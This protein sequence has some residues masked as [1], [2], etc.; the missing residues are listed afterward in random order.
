MTIANR[1]AKAVAVAKQGR[2]AE[3][4]SAAVED[5]TEALAARLLEVGS[6]CRF[7]ANHVMIEIGL[8]GSGLFLIREG[9][10]RVEAPERTVEMRAGE[11]VGDWALNRPDGLRTARVIC[12]T[13]V[14]AVAVDRPA[15]DAAVD[16]VAAAALAALPIASDNAPPRATAS[17]PRP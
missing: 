3:A 2:A 5:V 16:E 8:P 1:E 14:R 9:T 4:R 17:A 15:Y 12:T 13:D 6:E 7:P 10:V 11:I